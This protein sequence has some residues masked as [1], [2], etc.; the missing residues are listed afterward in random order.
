VTVLK[1]PSSIIC[2]QTSRRI[3]AETTV[4][5]TPPHTARSPPHAEG[6]CHQVRD[7][8]VS[9]CDSVIGMCTSLRVRPARILGP[10]SSAA[11]QK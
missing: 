4:W 9:E 11:P 3:R 10:R 8:V 7:V 5:K 1:N 6:L 2:D